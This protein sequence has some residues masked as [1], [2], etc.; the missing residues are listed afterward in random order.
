MSAEAESFTEPTDPRF[1]QEVERKTLRP[2]YDEDTGF[3]QEPFL[4]APEGFDTPFPVDDDVHFHG[5]V[6][7]IGAGKTTSGIIR[8]IANAE[9]WNPGETGMIVAPTV[10][11]LKNV[12]LPEMRKWGLL[13]HVR[14][15][16]KGSDEPGLHFP[17]G[18]RV[19]LESA[20]NARKIQRLRG[21]SISWFWIDEAAHLPEQ[22]WTTLVGRLRTGNY[23]NGFVTTTP[24]GKNWV[25]RRFYTHEGPNG[26]QVEGPPSDVNLVYGVPSTANPH[27]PDD[28]ADITSDYSGHE[29]EQEVLGLFVSPEGLVYQGFDPMDDVTDSVP[30]NPGRVLYGVD[31]GYRNPSAILAIVEDRTGGLTVVE[32]FYE[33]RVTTGDLADVATEMAGRWG[34]GTFYCDP[35]EPD[36]IEEFNRAGLDAV[37]ADN[38]I[39]P[40]I[41]TVTSH[42]DDLTVRESCQN[43]INEFTSYRYPDETG[44][45]NAKE[46]PVDANNHALDALRYALHTG[47]NGGHNIGAVGGNLYE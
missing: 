23:R 18:A 15:E 34:P 22:V 36:S 29:R 16:G 27:L 5:F 26:Q 6:S 12:I 33:N 21:P 10:P 9:S 40:G 4:A 47:M 2:W 37:E 13:D 38:D 32:E 28:Y 1:D 31:W 17:S 35:A 45:D 46:K 42:L 20:D 39:L 41:S 3:S 25:Y 8:V 19:I 44:E 43:V 24:A 14:Y 11:H 7:G 30:Q